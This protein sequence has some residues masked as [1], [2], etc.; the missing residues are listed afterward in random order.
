[1]PPAGGI[2][3]GACQAAK[4]FLEEAFG[5]ASPLVCQIAGEA[6]VELLVK[7]WSEALLKGVAATE[8]SKRHG[9]RA[10]DMKKPKPNPALLVSK[11]ALISAVA[12][13]E[14]S[15]LWL[16]NNHSSN[17]QRRLGAED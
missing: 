14:A 11:P 15:L 1:M 12:A 2:L 3:F 17:S 13:D 10:T 4:A 5:G 16:R 8:K 9:S 7:R 6:A